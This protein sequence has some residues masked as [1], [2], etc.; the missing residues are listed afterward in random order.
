MSV[1]KTLEDLT[2]GI[3]PEHD[4]EDFTT[5]TDQARI[6]RLEK[7]LEDVTI[8]C[9]HNFE[10]IKILVQYCKSNGLN[11][12]WDGYTPLSKPISQMTKEELTT[13]NKEGSERIRPKLMVRSKEAVKPPTYEDTTAMYVNEDMGSFMEL[14]R[15]AHGNNGIVTM[16]QLKE[17]LETLKNR[18][19]LQ[20]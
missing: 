19:Y 11:P 5:E 7:E 4:I 1:E 8:E 17:F 2:F 9:H 12:F 18:N 16:A 15:M 20:A 10:A 3:M 6:A 13:R 14:M